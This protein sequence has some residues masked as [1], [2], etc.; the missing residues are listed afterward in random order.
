MKRFNRII[1]YIMLFTL[2]FSFSPQAFGEAPNEPKLKEAKPLIKLDGYVFDGKGVPP[3]VPNGFKAS[4]LPVDQEALYIV[5]FT[6]PI[7]PEWRQKLIDLG[8]EIKG[9]VPDYAYLVKLTGTLK[10]QVQALPEVH[11]IVI[12]QPAYKL[13]RLL[14]KPEAKAKLNSAELLT[15]KVEVFEAQDLDGVK[16][17]ISSL[18]GKLLNSLSDTTILVKLPANQI[19]SLAQSIKVTYIEKYVPAKLNNDRAAKIMTVDAVYQPSSFGLTG[20]GETIAVVDTGLDNGNIATVHEDFRGQIVPGGVFAYG[21][22]GEWSDP[23]GHGTHVAGSAMGTGAASGGDFKGTAP[24]AKLIFQSVMD[25]GGG[26]NGLNHGLANIFGDARN[27]GARI[28]TNSWGAGPPSIWGYY[29]S[30]SAAVDNF[31]W[32]NKDMSILFAAGN[33]GMDYNVAAAAYSHQINS[34][35]TA[36]NTITVGA[37]E[38]LRFDQIPNP[39]GNDSGQRAYFSSMGPTADSRIKPDV[40]APGTWILS[41]KSG[42]APGGNFWAA[43]NAKYAYMGGTSM[44][45][46]LTAGLTASLRE[47]YRTREV[48]SNPSAALLKAT[49]TG[50][51]TDLGLPFD[52]QGFGRVNLEDAV[53]GLFNNTIQFVDNNVGLTTNQKSDYAFTTPANLPAGQAVTITLV[54]TDQPAF[55]N[56]NPTLVND[57]DLRAVEGGTT[58]YGNGV[59]G[60]DALNNV[61]QI[62]I[63]NA[64]PNKTYN[65]NINAFQAPQ[66]QPFALVYGT[67]PLHEGPTITV[68]NLYN[69][70]STN[71][72]TI[73]VSGKVDASTTLLTVNG[74]PAT[75]TNTAFSTSVNLLVGTNTITLQSRDAAGKLNTVTRTVTRFLPSATATPAGG[76]FETPTSVTMQSNVGGSTI[77]YTA[78]G[79]E[80]TTLSPVY[81]GPIAIN[82]NTNL[83]FM[84]KDTYGNNGP[85][86]TEKYY[87]TAQNVFRISGEVNLAGLTPDGLTVKAVRTSDQ[88]VIAQ[89]VFGAAYDTGVGEA[90]MTALPNGNVRVSLDLP[91]DVYQI[92]LTKGT[93]AAKAEINNT[94]PGTPLENGRH[95]KPFTLLTMAPKV[96]ENIT[97]A[98]ASLAMIS[99]TTQQ[100]TATG[101]YTDLSTQNI[102]GSV[103]W[104]SNN[105]AIAGVDSSGRVSA[106]AAGSTV[107]RAASGAVSADVN[108]NVTTATL[109]SITIS[110]VNPTKPKGRTQQFTATG[111]YDNGQNYNITNSVTWTSFTPAAVS[112]GSTT[113]LATAAGEGSSTITA[114]L[115][116]VTSNTATMTVTAPVVDSV[117][118]TP[119]NLSLAKGL[120]QQFNVNGTYSDGTVLNLNNTAVWSSLNAIFASV[121]ATG[122]VTAANTGTATIQAVYNSLIGQAAVTVTPPQL[123]TLVIS[124]AGSTVERGNTLQLTAMGSYTD[125]TTQNLSNTVAWSS[126]N[127]AVATINASGLV[128]TF[129]AGSTTITA[130]KDG[131]SNSTGV[132]VQDTIAPAVLSKSPD[133]NAGNV[134]VGTNI[135]VNFSEPMDASTL[136]STTT[137]VT[138]VYGATPVTITY[139]SANRRVTITPNAALKYLTEYTVTLSTG[140]KDPAGNALNATTWKFTTEADK[141]PPLIG[142]RNPAE[143]A[144]GVAVGSNIEF[145]FN[146]DVVADTV[147]GAAYANNILLKK[148]TENIAV[149]KTFDSVN[150][151]VTIDPVNNLAEG[152]TYTV[153]VTGVKDLLGNTMLTTSWNFTTYQPPAPGGGGGGGGVPPIPATPTTDIEQ[154]VLAAGGELV[155]RDG[156]VKIIIPQDA[157][158]PGQT[159]NLTAKKLDAGTV[160]TSPPAGLRLA[161]DIYE[162]GPAGQ[163]FSK[164]IRITLKYRPEIVTNGDPAAYYLN[165]AKNLWEPVPNITVNKNA[166]TVTFEANHF[167]KYTVMAKTPEKAPETVKTFADIAGHWAKADIELI[168]AKGIVSGK[169][170]NLFDPNGKVTRAEFAAIVA[171][172]LNLAPQAA[173][174][175]FNDVQAADWYAG[176]VGAAV[177][178][179]IIK[180]YADGSFKPNAHVTRQE[181]AAMVVQAMKAA[182]VDIAI[183]EAEINQYLTQFKDGDKISAWAKAVVAVAAKNNII[184]G[185]AKGEFAPANNSTRA[186]AVVMIKQ[187]LTRAKLI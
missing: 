45:T 65:I 122:L 12:Y 15:L 178:A 14:K 136:N 177:E 165:A 97:I 120:T 114:S 121:N 169:A 167:S 157:L 80:P 74:T 94:L 132:T 34:P 46:P 175:S 18:S 119:A 183:T 87:F 7:M 32:N 160:R 69:G 141:Y 64:L 158:R 181:V 142:G 47:Y 170:A 36:K 113:G 8:A 172:A 43:Y 16:K 118:V 29:T 154:T 187:L 71:Q 23:D 53:I 37:V 100:L 166:N 98:P 88:A 51:A 185:N 161:G 60:G 68:D 147:Y 174:A 137:T 90:A 148:G 163:Q 79:T 155:S 111:S 103:A 30:D 146:E 89:T 184:K 143:N 129:T 22:P 10:N 186:E 156:T 9:Y 131:V 116:A 179:G 62:Y 104:S 168:A 49:L 75:V 11:V 127:P 39:D 84:A 106:I 140:V 91:Q 67:I 93:N 108:V 57:L 26:L 44:A 28:S 115:G 82:S 56:A 83:K 92:V 133:H 130:A 150:K 61:E 58:F 52:Q 162:F 19:A 138:S 24:N 2:I 81:A 124:P 72:P 1:S 77:Y 96:L 151:K 176:A 144:A 152:T 139:D 159:I 182:K 117:S 78:D 25:S 153:T 99:G 63:P 101:Y 164:P 54:W 33:E 13:D 59:V 107:I 35:G 171:K 6:G 3:A 4:N 86:Q 135:Q 123:T 31:I 112:I 70:F 17:T 38:N 21:R 55:A 149:I 76:V 48:V 102:T 5:Q 110:P 73:T 180:G 109:Q 128:T 50:T 27:L 126:S 41:S 40:V 145:N 66:A 134:P 95:L 20:N 105:S 173:K 42:L 85:V 125:S